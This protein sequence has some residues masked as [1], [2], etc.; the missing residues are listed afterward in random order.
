MPLPGLPT[1]AVPPT[2]EQLWR[3]TKG[4]RVVVCWRRRHPLGFELRLELQGDT[5]RTAVY[6]TVDEAQAAEAHMREAMVERGWT[7]GA[8]GSRPGPR[9][10]EG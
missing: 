10:A 1:D 5:I 2:D 7:V 4:R 8:I 9:L 6:P 3:L